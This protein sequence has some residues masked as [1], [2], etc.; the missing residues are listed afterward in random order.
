MEDFASTLPGVSGR[1][2]Y[3]LFEEIRAAPEVPFEIFVKVTD[4]ALSLKTKVA[5]S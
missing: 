5:M 1:Y 2:P 4:R 3:P